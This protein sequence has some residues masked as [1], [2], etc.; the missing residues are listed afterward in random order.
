MRISQTRDGSRAPFD[1][2]TIFLHWLVVLLVVSL[3]ATGLAFARLPAMVG[4]PLL[5]NLHRAAGG[6]LW[7]VML[8]RLLWRSTAA[9]FPPFPERMPRFQQ[10]LATLSE[11]LLY[12]LLLLQPLLGLAMSLSLGRPFRLI[13]WDVPSLAPRNLALWL[14]LLELHRVGAYAL[15]LLASGHAIMALL[16]PFRLRHAA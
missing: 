11:H 1:R 9:R 10:R 4:A 13:V 7:G 2:L 3:A 15:F 5:L 16:H 8:L 12:L 6:I 14:V